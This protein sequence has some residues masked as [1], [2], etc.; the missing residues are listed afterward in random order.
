MAF[1][2]A[3]LVFAAV[4]GRLDSRLP[5]PSPARRRGTPRTAATA[6]ATATTAPGPT[7]A[8]ES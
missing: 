3:V 7:A 8:K 6:R 2:F 5:W 4:L 1:V